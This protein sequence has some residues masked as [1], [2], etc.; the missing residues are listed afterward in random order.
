ERGL[1]SW[2]RGRKEQRAVGVHRRNRL[3]V[4][5]VADLVGA[6][7]PDVAHR[8]RGVAPQLALVAGVVLHAIRI[9]DVVVDQIEPQ[10]RRQSRRRRVRER[11]G[12]GG[13]GGVGK[14]RGGVGGGGGG[15]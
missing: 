12:V 2:A 3:V 6:A 15:V 4:L 7:R 1:A 11:R 13:G 10:E 8:R 14:R 5:D 9:L